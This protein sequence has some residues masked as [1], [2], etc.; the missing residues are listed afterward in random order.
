MLL[1]KQVLVLTLEQKSSQTSNVE[2]QVLKPD[3]VVL[4]A[5]VRALK[6]NGG[7][8]KEDLSEENLDALAKGIV[9]LEKHIENLQKFGVPVV[10][11]LNQFITD[12][13]AEYEYIKNF[14]EERGCEFALAEVWDKRWRRRNRISRKG[15]RNNRNKTFKLC[16]FIS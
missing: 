9:N 2:K 15:Y 3:C 8:A 11:T 10:V 16:T 7:V 14:C 5:T 6:Y 13:E 1:Q 4:V 12:T